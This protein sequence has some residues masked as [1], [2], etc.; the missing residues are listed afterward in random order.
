MHEPPD[1][2][3]AACMFC[4]CGAGAVPLAQLQET[5]ASLS[6]QAVHPCS[7]MRSKIAATTM[8]SRR[9]ARTWVQA[10]SATV[11]SKR[12]LP[13]T[14][15]VRA[16]GSYSLEPAL[17]QYQYILNPKLYVSPSI[18]T[19][20]RCSPSCSPPSRPSACRPSAAMSPP[21]LSMPVVRNVRCQ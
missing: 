11:Q 9:A 13:T 20:S 16:L 8:L 3:S 14:S 18:L 15:A 5:L 10:P 4:I 19:L 7:S 1:Q 17:A 2:L 12:C 6:I 21:G